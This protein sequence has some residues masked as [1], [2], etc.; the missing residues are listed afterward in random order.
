MKERTAAY[1]QEKARMTEPGYL[2]ICQIACEDCPL[3]EDN[4]GRRVNCRDLEDFYTEQAIL[5]VQKWST[6][7]PRKTILQD[8][9]EKYQDAPLDNVGVPKY[10]CPF[11]LGYGENTC[12]A[13]S[14]EECGV[15]WNR[16]LEEVRK[17]DTK[18]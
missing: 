18:E 2:G 7:H 15:C 1:F 17:D 11:Y 8:F 4:N 12:K 3:S 16:P 9:L 6:A 5:I 14:D 13:I 10:V